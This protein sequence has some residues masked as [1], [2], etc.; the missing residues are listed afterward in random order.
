MNI[1]VV[2]EVRDA[3]FWLFWRQYNIH[4][5]LRT[6]WPKIV[7]LVWRRESVK[8]K[9]FSNFSSKKQSRLLEPSKMGTCVK[10]LTAGSTDP[11]P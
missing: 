4:E 6:T 1:R 5:F 3:Q 8:N 7:T 11:A 9:F 2:A 10:T